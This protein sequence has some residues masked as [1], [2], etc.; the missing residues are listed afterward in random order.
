MNF[1]D[2]LEQALPAV[3]DDGFSA[4]EVLHLNRGRQ[5]WRNLAW[6]LA[7]ALAIG[8]AWVLPFVQESAMAAV[9]LATMASSQ[10][11][12]YVAGALILLWTCQPRLFHLQ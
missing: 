1:D 8:F 5:R 9:W 10:I 6:A 3:C 7:M 11:F 4:Q 12:A 2:L